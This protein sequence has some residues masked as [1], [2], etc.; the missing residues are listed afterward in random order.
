MMILCVCTY[1]HIHC[2]YICEYW[3]CTYSYT[4]GVFQSRSLQLE[5]S[6]ID[7]T[8]VY[9]TPNNTGRRQVVCV[10]VCVWVGVWVGFCRWGCG[11]WLCAWSVQVCKYEFPEIYDARSPTSPT[12]C[13]PVSPCNTPHSHS[14]LHNYM[15]VYATYVRTLILIEFRVLFSCNQ[16]TVCSG[17]V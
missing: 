13:Q 7:L 9:Y 6:G 16:D 17:Y 11:G 10:C 14:A 8:V 12:F 15:C 3:L 5:G 1:V 4:L 2:T